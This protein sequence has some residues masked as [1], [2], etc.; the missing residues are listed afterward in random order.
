[1]LE[2]AQELFFTRGMDIIAAVLI[3]I[4]GKWVARLVSVIVE[5][6]LIRSRCESTLTAFTK[7]IVYFGIFIFVILAALSKV[8]FQTTSFVAL[9]GAAGLAI[10]LA[11]QGSLSNFAAGVLLILFQPFKANDYIE[12]AGTEGSVRE[13]QIFNTVLSGKDS[14]LVIIPNSK[15]TADKIIVHPLKAK[16]V[17]D[18]QEAAGQVRS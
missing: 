1:M 6:S 2:K 13:I 11:L 17:L 7:N 10:G 16:S 5:K 12:A 4:V 8:G 15:I 18:K 3:V 14:T 9:I